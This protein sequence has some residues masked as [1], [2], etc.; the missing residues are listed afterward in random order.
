MSQV[1]GDDQRSLVRDCWERKY[2]QK[3]KA[4]FPSVITVKRH[5]RRITTNEND[6]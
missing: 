4:F 6:I 5:R 2:I 1:V 3:D